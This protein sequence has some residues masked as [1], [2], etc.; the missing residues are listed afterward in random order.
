MQR[1]REFRAKQPHPFPNR[2][3]LVGAGLRPDATWRPYQI[4]SK[5]SLT[6]VKGNG[7]KSHLT[8]VNGIA[9]GRAGDGVC[10]DN[11]VVVV[12]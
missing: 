6:V 12:V 2:R 1:P 11:G 7:W 3:E 10:V 4:R 9:G 8:V 5:S